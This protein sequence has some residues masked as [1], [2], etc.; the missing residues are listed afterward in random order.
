MSGS[1]VIIQTSSKNRREHGKH[2]G[3]TAVASGISTGLSTHNRRRT[4]LRFSGVLADDSVSRRTSV[5][6]LGTAPDGGDDR[7]EE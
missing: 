5:R 2:S 6:P 3:K 4:E 7:R 1:F